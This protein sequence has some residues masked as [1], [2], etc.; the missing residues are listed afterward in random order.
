ME[1]QQ[2]ENGKEGKF[3]IEQDGSR[4]AT[5]FYSWAGDDRIIIS[6]TEVDGQME[7]KGIG[8]KLVA[9]AV[10]FAREKKV[11]IVPACSFAKI[12]FERT[13]EYSDLL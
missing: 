2:Q 7:G 4:V 6:H 13:P 12:I 1:I 8:K 10:K 5:L 9:Q 3:F 11:K